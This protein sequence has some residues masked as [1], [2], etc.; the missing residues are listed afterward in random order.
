MFQVLSED[1][2]D[3]STAAI[4][5]TLVK[6][7]HYYVRVSDDIQITIEAPM[8]ERKWSYTVG[9]KA[10]RKTCRRQLVTIQSFCRLQ[11]R[12]VLAN[13]LS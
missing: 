13:V 11:S 3:F 10:S 9:N 8:L 2:P 4:T 5:S 6:S 7:Q 1:C 12:V